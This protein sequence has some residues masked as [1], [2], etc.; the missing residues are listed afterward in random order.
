[1][2]LSEKKLKNLHDGLRLEEVTREAGYL[3]FVKA[4]TSD[5]IEIRYYE[6]GLYVLEFESEN[7]TEAK[8]K[9]E[10]YFENQLSPAISYIFSLGAPTPKV[11]ANI[12][13]V[14]PTVI[15]LVH[16]SPES[17]DVPGE[18]GEVYS[19]ISSEGVSV[20]KTPESIFVVSGQ[21]SAHLVAGLVEMQIFF[22]EFKDQLEKYLNIH[23]SIWEE[24]ADIKERHTIKGNEIE[25]LRAK[26]DSY[27]KTVSL[28]GNRINQMGAYVRTRAAI[29]KNLALEQ[30]L[31]SLFQF[32][33]EILTDTLDYIKELWKMTIDYLMQA[34]QVVVEV[35]NQGTT[36]GIQ[37][38]QLITSI[39]VVSGL[40]GYFGRNEF[41]KFTG[42]GIVYFLLI[43]GITWFINRAVTK[44][45]T[46]KKY[47]LK[48]AERTTK[49]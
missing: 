2:D 36:R 12:K 32:K 23:R 41:P 8:K 49:L 28:I 19:R 7:I 47:Q 20:Y 42:I 17:F 27:Q 11:L 37:S 24:I 4:R 30:Q 33:F 16:E 14:H 35:K 22:R 46:R 45:Y 29:S 34:I 38:L 39:G 6:D 48:F 43:I 31:V 21:K 44:I 10:D 3:E 1:M 18:Y 15:S 9:L 13:T 40:L 5:G 25:S 26:L